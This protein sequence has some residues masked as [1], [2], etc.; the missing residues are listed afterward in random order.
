MSL[1][2]AWRSLVVN[3]MHSKYE[4]DKNEEERQRDIKW[5]QEENV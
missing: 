1:S 2:Q 4:R 3:G 5:R